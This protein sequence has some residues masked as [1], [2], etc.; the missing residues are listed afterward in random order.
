MSIEAIDEYLAIA[1]YCVTTEKAP[2]ALYGYPAVLL[3]LSVVDTLSNYLGYPEHSFQILRDFDPSLNLLQVKSLKNWYRNLPAHQAIIMPGTLLSPDPT[4]PP[5]TLGA[6]G[7]PTHIRVIPFYHLV[8]SGW[9][10]FDK[11][12]V[13]PKFVSKQGPGAP[14]DLSASPSSSL[15]G[16][17]GCMTSAK[18]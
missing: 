11:R 9:D 12:K 17:S 7:E 2:G 3:L 18:P 16:L 10:K 14:I 15:P 13:N 6:V 4:G 8:K 1:H 5:I